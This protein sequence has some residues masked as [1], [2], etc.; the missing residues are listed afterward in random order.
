[1]STHIPVNHPLRPL[2]RVLAALVGIYTLIFG[3]VGFTQTQGKPLFAQSNLPWVLGLRTNL[4]FALLSVGGGAVLLLAVIIGRNLDYFVNIVGG[5]IF[6]VVGMLMLGLLQTD[7][8]FLGFTVTNCIV[9]FILGTI[10][11]TAGLYGR[12]GSESQG[13]H[14]YG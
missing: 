1:M 4:A 2:Y 12:T 13:T 9:S 8:N 7:A 5:L 10:V 3:I 14:H 11:F 6:M